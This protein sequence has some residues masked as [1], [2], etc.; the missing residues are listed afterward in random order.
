MFK[1]ESI[2]EVILVK[3]LQ[4]YFK[5]LYECKTVFFEHHDSYLYNRCRWWIYEYYNK[6]KKKML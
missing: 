4:L 1:I 2:N 3:N 6:K 5:F